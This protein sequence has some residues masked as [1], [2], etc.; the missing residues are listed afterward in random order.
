M[1]LLAERTKRLILEPIFAN[2][3]AA[4]IG[5]VFIAGCARRKHPWI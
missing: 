2:I 5:S 1:K 3:F 4:L